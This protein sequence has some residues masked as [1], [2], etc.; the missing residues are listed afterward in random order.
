MVILLVV[1]VSAQE[2]PE[3]EP[4]D[5]NCPIKKSPDYVCDATVNLASNTSCWMP[6]NTCEEK[7]EDRCFCRNHPNK[8]FYG[9]CMVTWRCI[10][11]P[12]STSTPVTTE[13]I[14]D[15]QG[16]WTVG[17]IVAISVVVTITVV[18]AI[19]IGCYWWIIKCHIPSILG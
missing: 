3:A 7:E 17:Q 19:A 1:C 8:R 12:I 5:K 18:V 16:N 10:Y 6:S 13:K 15:E 2:T 9:K 14:P 11:V 4:V